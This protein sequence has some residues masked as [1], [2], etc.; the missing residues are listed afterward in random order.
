MINN[1]Y[2]AAVLTL[3]DKEYQIDEQKMRDYV[4]FLL[5][6][7]IKGFFP[8]GT[9]GEY[10]GHTA[11]ENLQLLKI[12]IDENKGRKPVIPCAS[13][14]NLWATVELIKNMEQ[15]GITQVSVCPPYYTP[16]RQCDIYDYYLKILN[17]T[18]VD[19]YLYNIPS[20]TNNLQF[21]TFE[22]LLM[23]PKIIGIKDSSGSMKTISRY[24]TVKNNCRPDFRVMTGTDEMILPSLV[25]GC[26]GSVS[27][28]SGIIPEVHNELY[29]IYESDLN[30]AKKL[31]HEITNLAALCE[32][33]VFPVGYKLALQARGFE[34]GPF[35]QNVCE[36]E[37]YIEQLK[38]SIKSSI[39]RLENMIGG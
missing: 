32:N 31:Q 20:F 8:A 30:L 34:V 28:L 36:S 7:D 23:E 3:Y 4:Q 37:D 26:F 19:I 39:R 9:S 12:V 18:S 13:T 5:N 16:L 21:D 14:S 1:S 22:R 10:V 25:A 2:Y 15:L 35:R 6:K 29:H 24:I 27:A 11:A 17:E 38:T 33:I